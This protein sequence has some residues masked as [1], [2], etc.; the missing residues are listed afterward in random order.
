MKLD[1]NQKE[2]CISKLDLR[3]ATHGLKLIE[4]QLG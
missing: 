4:G 3:T 2:S 1:H